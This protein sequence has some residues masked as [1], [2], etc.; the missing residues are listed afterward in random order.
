MRN[1]QLGKRRL[2]PKHPVH[3]GNVEPHDLKVVHGRC[4]GEP[5]RLAGETTFTKE[6]PF[7]VN[8]DDPFLALLRNHGDFAVATTNVENAVASVPLGED[9]IPLAVGCDGPAP[10]YGGVP[11]TTLKGAGS[12]NHW[13]V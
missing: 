10:V 9:N 12:L 7:F 13:R 11:D 4:C 1:E 2:L 8:G 3:G 5:K 6:I